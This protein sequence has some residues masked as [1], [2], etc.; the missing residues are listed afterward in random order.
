MNSVL[1]SLLTSGHNRWWPSPLVNIITV[2]QGE[3]EIDIRWEQTAGEPQ[4]NA[5][6][7]YALLLEINF[8]SPECWMQCQAGTL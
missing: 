8:I 2:S 7:F 6:S 3:T 4:A 5:G 1:E